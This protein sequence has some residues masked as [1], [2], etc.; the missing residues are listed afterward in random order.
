VDGVWS[1]GDA[2]S[3][4][5]EAGE[6]TEGAGRCTS[7]QG[8]PCLSVREEEREHALPGESGQCMGPVSNGLKNNP[9]LIQTCPDLI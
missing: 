6:E 1:G 5:G 2:G 9:N 7:R 8:G 4:T 3:R